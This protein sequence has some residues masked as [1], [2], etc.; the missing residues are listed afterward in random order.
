M[1]KIAPTI[2]IT[3]LVLSIALPVNAQITTKCTVDDSLFVAFDF[4]NL[5]QAVYDEAVTQ[6]NAET[7]PKAIVEDLE[8]KNQTR[9]HYGLGPQPITFDN[10]TKTIHASFFLGGSDIISFSMQK[11]TMKR[12]YQVKTDWRRFQVDLTSSFSVD[13]AQHFAKLVVEWQ[14][15]NYTD[16]QGSVHPAYY[17]ESEQTGAFQMFFYFILP[18]SAQRVQVQRDTITYDMPPRFED[19]LLNSPFLILGGLA[20]ILIIVLIYRKIR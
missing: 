9:V 16:T 6:L 13:F 12:A 15:I 5:N 17:H 7:I 8:A 2:F 1:K 11:F 19:Q 10:N 20:V 4:Q 3:V 18:A 14:R